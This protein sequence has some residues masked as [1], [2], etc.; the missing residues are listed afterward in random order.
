MATHLN[1]YIKLLQNVWNLLHKNCVQEFVSIR[2]RNMRTKIQQTISR[3]NL[4][5]HDFPIFLSSCSPHVPLKTLLLGSGETSWIRYFEQGRIK[6]WGQGVLWQ[7]G[8]NCG[9][10][11]PSPQAERLLDRNSLLLLL[12]SKRYGSQYLQCCKYADRDGGH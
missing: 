12:F 8:K 5:K 10:G 4:A 2:S 1:K 11:L 9:N 3:V 6:T 7:K